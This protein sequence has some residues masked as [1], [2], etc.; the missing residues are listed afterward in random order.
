M[1]HPPIHDKH[2]HTY[3]GVCIHCSATPACTHACTHKQ[4]VWYTDLPPSLKLMT[5]QVL[6]T[7]AQPL[8]ACL[9]F[10]TSVK[11]PYE[12]SDL[13]KV[14]RWAALHMSVYYE[15]LQGP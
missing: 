4:A 1:F 11:G 15:S 6:C 13:D 8:V 3:I 7:H 10:P 14:E 5:V 2:A 9:C 12:I